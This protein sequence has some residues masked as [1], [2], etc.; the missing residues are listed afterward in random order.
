MLYRCQYCIVGI[1]IGTTYVKL[2]VPYR[3]SILYLF[4]NGVNRFWKIIECDIRS[5]MLQLFASTTC[6]TKSP[7][8]LK[9]LLWDQLRKQHHLQ[10]NNKVLFLL[11]GVTVISP[12]VQVSDGIAAVACN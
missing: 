9:L 6:I 7:P 4:C 8:G 12:S 3:C 5:V 2:I 10:N 1:S 11:D